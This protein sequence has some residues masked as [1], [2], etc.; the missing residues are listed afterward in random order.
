T[1]SILELARRFAEQKDREGRR[2]IFMTFAGEEQGL[3]GSRHYCNNPTFPLDK[4]AAMVNLDMVGRVRPDKDTKKDKLEVSGIGSAKP[5]FE[6][7]VDDLNK[8][9]DFKLSKVAS[10]YGPSDHTSFAQ[11]KVPVVNY[12]TGLHSEYHKPADTIETINFEGMK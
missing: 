11:K 12:F 1:V 7:M 4:T 10:G 3:L 2:L 9:Y 5:P 6:P 8:K